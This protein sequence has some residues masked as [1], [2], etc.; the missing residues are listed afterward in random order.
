MGILDNLLNK[1]LDV[2]DGLTSGALIR[3]VLRS[4]S[5]D[6]MDRQHQQLFEGKAP[7]GEDIRPYYSEDLQPSGY[8][9][10]KE[11]ALKYAEWKR[12]LSYPV[13]ATRNEDAPNL[14]INGKF[15]S[16]LDVTFNSD[17]VA[18]KGDTGYAQK[19]VAKYGMAQFGLSMAN[20]MDI[21]ENC[22]AL[23]ELTA[24]IKDIL[25]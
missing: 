22:K 15:H 4:H 14:Y 5:D 7:S 16:E 8:F 20:W 18:I 24:E 12:S 1:V 25:W 23:E 17:A 19:I 10:T 13:Q 3:E 21:F 2:N 6:I 11:A 9:K